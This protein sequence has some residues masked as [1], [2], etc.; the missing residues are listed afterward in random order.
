MTALK[1]RLGD[2]ER[3]RTDLAATVRFLTD[4]ASNTAVQGGPVGAPL[5]SD[6]ANAGPVRGTR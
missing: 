1:A 4:D 6:A 2:L 3:E 5:T